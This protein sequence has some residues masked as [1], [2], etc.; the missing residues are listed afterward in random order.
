MFFREIYENFTQKINFIWSILILIQ[1]FCR[2]LFQDVLVTRKGIDHGTIDLI[3][4]QVSNP[5][6]YQ[7]SQR[8]EGVLRTV[9]M[10]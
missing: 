2:N 8:N 10:I 1:W 6:W 5:Q 7:T 9:H 3:G 4:Y